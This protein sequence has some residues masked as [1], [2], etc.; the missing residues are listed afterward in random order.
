[1]INFQEIDLIIWDW[2]KTLSDYH[3]YQDIAENY[4]DE[5]K[6]I[7]EHLRE[8]PDI[9]RSWVNGK[10]KFN[11]LHSIFEEVS[12]I[13]ADEF[14][15]SIN[16][17][18]VD[19]IEPKITKHVKKLNSQ[20]KSQIIAS[21]NFEVWDEFLLPAYADKLNE[22]FMQVSY[23][24]QSFFGKS[25][26]L[27]DLAY[28]EKI[29]DSLNTKPERTLLVDDNLMLTKKFSNELGGKSLVHNG[30]SD[31]NKKLTSNIS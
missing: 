26:E 18:T 1:M 29:I 12:N 31:L 3:F 13:P 8:H 24:F 4:P 25:E 22:Y 27:L 21:D 15:E 30:I 10:L 2:Y 9:V 16:L 5:F 7:G 28:Y 17:I 23:N 19:L 6:K 11:D 14:D 20:G